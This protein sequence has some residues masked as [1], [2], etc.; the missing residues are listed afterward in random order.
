MPQ[1]IELSLV[2]WSTVSQ[3]LRPLGAARTMWVYF[4]LCQLRVHFVLEVLAKLMVGENL[5]WE[6][7]KVGG[8][9]LIL[10]VHHV[11]ETRRY[12]YHTIWFRSRRCG[13]LVTWFCYQLIAKPGN[14]TAWATPL[15]PETY[16]HCYQTC[17]WV[18]GC[19]QSAMDCHVL[20]TWS[21][22]VSCF[23]L[24]S[25]YLFLVACTVFLCILYYKSRKT[26]L[27]G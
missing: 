6:F 1:T 9:R 23:C 24:S 3:N 14:K 18:N 7:P 19:F 17:H 26:C 27:P 2:L 16:D 5:R 12:C 22:L 21:Y 4:S 13:C 11:L 15:W 8:V 10:E 25:Q 20:T